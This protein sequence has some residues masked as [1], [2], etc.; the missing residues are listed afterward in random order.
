[1]KQNEKLQQLQ[2]MKKHLDA[3]FHCADKIIETMRDKTIHGFRF[4][5][6]TVFVAYPTASHGGIVMIEFRN[7]AEVRRE[8]GYL[9]EINARYRQYL[10]VRFEAKPI[11][12]ALGQ[13][14]DYRRSCRDDGEV[15]QQ[16]RSVIKSGNGAQHV[17]I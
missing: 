11:H 14:L 6:G 3:Q 12:E 17:E 5:K 1:M 13:A 7:R 10:A 2:E 8:Y 16:D 15:A 9:D 4:G